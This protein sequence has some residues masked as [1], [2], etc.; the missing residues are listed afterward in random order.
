MKLKTKL[1]L[2]FA[3]VIALMVISS[4]IVWLKVSTETLQ[5]EE[6]KNDDLPGL[7]AYL[8]ISDTIYQMQNE[9]LEYIGGEQQKR[10]SFAALH[11][12]FQTQHQELYKYE[13]NKPSDIEKMANIENLVKEY[14]R[15]ITEGVFN[16]YDPE[17]F[18]SVQSRVAQLE[19]DTGE[20]L[21]DLLDELK[22]QE[23][24]Q[25][26]QARDLQ[27]SLQDNLP[28]VRYYLELIDEAGDLVAGVNA[29]IRGDTEAKARFK[30]DLTS[31][32]EYLE[33][34]RPLEQQPDEIAAL[35]QVE[36]YRDDIVRTANS[37]FTS[38]SPQ[39]YIDAR[40]TINDLEAQVV[41]KI[42]TILQTS[43]REEQ[44][45]AISALNH[46]VEGL[47]LTLIIIVIITLIAFVVA[48]II[49]YLISHSIIT[50]LNNVLETA[51][52]VSIGDLSRPAIAHANKDE[53]DSLAAATNKMSSS[54]HDLMALITSLA[55]QVRESSLEISS[56]N[57]QI[58]NRS[59]NSADQST[60]IATAIEEMSST[61]SEVA[62]QSQQASGN[63]EQAREYAAHGAEAVSQT[64]AE[65]RSASSRVQNT[66]SSV[67]ELG[68]LSNQIGNII[69]V[70]S[71]IAEQTNL[72][73]LNAAI[74]AARAGEQG[75]GFA[76]VADEVR[77]LAERTTK[78]TDEVAQTITAIQKQTHQAVESMH[79]SVEQVNS[80]VSMA[81]QAGEQLSNIMQSA[82]DIAS[83]IQSIA[84]ATEEQSVVAA[85]MAK[86]VSDIERAS[87]ASL[88]DT[89]GALEI[90][91]QLNSQAGELSESVQR[92]K[93]RAS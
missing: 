87:Q 63:S 81:E 30:D 86:D 21:G 24:A 93:L 9:A 31:F 27:T 90:A 91:K 2:S 28:G 13:S 34:L 14:N 64:V 67:T 45:D 6:V 18:R 75:R 44:V 52:S 71:A 43:A 25:A 36:S 65:I 8:S 20:K 42:N 85:E 11:R 40:S 61:V 70:I 60:Q 15:G 41:D 80:S 5:A 26:M 35:R 55:T 12:Q 66:S 29:H 68:E 33:A 51:E 53:I 57:E 56:T 54:L 3:A 72:L 47:N 38:Y 82:S 89:Q 7:L 37:I 69:S 4:L 78:A 74:E 73:A 84:T 76:V 1:S 23:Y 49:A 32:N 79:S 88:N 19:Q 10:D 17:L 46:L 22:D 59:Q 83:M 58:A 62:R 39:D 16:R 77:T 92:F 50:R 48:G